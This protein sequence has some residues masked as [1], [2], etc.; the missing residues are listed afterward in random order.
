MLQNN[1]GSYSIGL[2]TN[3]GTHN[4]GTEAV[5]IG[6]NAG[7]NAT[8]GENVVIGARAGDYLQG[9]DNVAIG[10][11]AWAS[12]VEDAGSSQNVADATTDINLALDRVTITAHGFG[13][14]SAYVSLKYTAG[15][16]P[17]GGLTNGSVYQVQIIDANTFE[18]FRDDLTTNGTDTHSF[19]LGTHLYSNTVSLGANSVPNASNQIMLGDSTTVTTL[20]AR[21]YIF[22]IDQTVGAAQDGFA[23]AYNDSSGEI[24]L[25]SNTKIFSLTAV[26]SQSAVTTGDAKASMSVGASL[27]GYDLVS[28]TVTVEDKGVTGTT[29]VVLRSWRGGVAA[30][31]TSTGVTVGDE[32]FAADSTIDTANDDVLQGDRIYIDIDAIHSGTAPNGCDVVLEFR[33]P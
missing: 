29:H 25:I 27:D 8:G 33:K 1:L 28:V 21:N 22:N 24:E 5:S 26:D 15:A 23:L 9:V 4:V 17:I 19:A 16:T 10:T 12:F 6:R 18:F 30:A 20:V 7:Q 3:A 13:A 2:G 14:T 31:L 11:D 32:W